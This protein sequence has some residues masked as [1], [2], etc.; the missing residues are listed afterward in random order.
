MIAANTRAVRP[1]ALAFFAFRLGVVFF[2]VAL[3]SDAAFS[4]RTLSHLAFVAA[5]IAARPAL[6]I[7]RFGFAAGFAASA[8]SDLA[9]A[10]LFFWPIAILRRAAA[11]IFLFLGADCVPSV[12]AGGRPGPR[13][14]KRDRIPAIASSIRLNCD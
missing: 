12:E 2:A 9:A 3:F 5:M 6:L 13:S 11:V 14:P 7:L 8:F 10:H 4:L 1:F